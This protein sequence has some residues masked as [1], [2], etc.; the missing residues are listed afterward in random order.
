VLDSMSAGGDDTRCGLARG[1]TLMRMALD[2]APQ[3]EHRDP[4]H[5]I[6]Y[7]SVLR[8]DSLGSRL[9][10]RLVLVGFENPG[11]VFSVVRGLSKEPRFA[12]ELEADA[13]NTLLRGIRIAPLGTRAQFIV[14]LGMAAL[15]ALAAYL[16][17]RLGRIAAALAAAAGLVAYFVG[18]ASLYAHHHA[19]LNTLFDFAALVLAF[20]AVLGARKVWFP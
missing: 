14:I 18:G 7:L 11:S 6:S 17:A 5:R 16:I 2:Y 12:V 8:G 4:A 9:R 15:G 20:T 13:M 10:G 1:D 19:L 3:D